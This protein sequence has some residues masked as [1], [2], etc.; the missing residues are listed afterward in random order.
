MA[1]YSEGKKRGDNIDLN[2]NIIKRLNKTSNHIYFKEKF[3]QIFNSYL[4]KAEIY[5]EL[6]KYENIDLLFLVVFKNLIKD[7]KEV[8]LSE[9][10]FDNDLSFNY[11]I[12]KT[13]KEQEKVMLS[14]TGVILTETDITQKFKINDRKKIYNAINIIKIFNYCSTFQNNNREANEDLIF[15]LSRIAD[16]ILF[17]YDNDYDIKDFEINLYDKIKLELYKTN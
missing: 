4:N 11:L 7:K 3:D 10:L 6:I 2:I 1:K 12:K 13:I 16:V 9:E 17:D 14:Y 8:F 5:N 15:R